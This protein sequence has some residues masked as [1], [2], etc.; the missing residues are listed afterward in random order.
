[1][2]LHVLG[3]Q[4]LSAKLFVANIAV[5]RFFV[6]GVA[7]FVDHKFVFEQKALAAHSALKLQFTYDFKVMYE[8]KSW[9]NKFVKLPKCLRLECF[10]K[11]L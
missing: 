1:M 6:S 10:R 5:V 3:E 8:L 4:K 2:R 7:Q 9:K 11:A